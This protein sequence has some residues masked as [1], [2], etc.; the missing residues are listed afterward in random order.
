LFRFSDQYFIYIS[1][2]IHAFYISSS[3]FCP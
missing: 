2:F 3:S 1:N